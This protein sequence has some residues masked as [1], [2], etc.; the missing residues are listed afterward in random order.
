[1]SGDLGVV[2]TTKFSET[3]H[4]VLLADLKGNDRAARK[5]LN[6]GEVLWE[7]S[8]VHLVEFFDD[9]TVEIEHFH[10]ADLEASLKDHF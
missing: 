2:R 8:L 6:D 9:R 5:V 3:R 4:C 10:A 1:M 7:H